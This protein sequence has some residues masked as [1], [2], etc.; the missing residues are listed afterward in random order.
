MAYLEL[1]DH[2][3]KITPYT[4]TPTQKRKNNKDNFIFK[5]PLNLKI[6]SQTMFLIKKVK[7]GAR[8]KIFL[9]LNQIIISSLENNFNPSEKGCKR[10]SHP[11][12]LGPFRFCLNLNTFRSNN[13]KKATQIN[14]Q[15]KTSIK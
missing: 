13:V 12:L 3:E 1:D 11:T 10:P 8:K 2:P 6:M 4:L 9:L 5:N 15:I 7:K 14:T